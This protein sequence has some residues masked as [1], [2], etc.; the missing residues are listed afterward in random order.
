LSEDFLTLTLDGETYHRMDTSA[1]EW[2]YGYEVNLNLTQTQLELVKEGTV[3]FDHSNVI[4]EVNLYYQDGSSLYA[5]Y[6]KDSQR[7]RLIAML[8]D[9]NAVVEIEYWNNSNFTK[10]S[11]KDYK[12]NAIVLSERILSYCDYYYVFGHAEDLDIYTRPGALLVEQG[13]YYY[14]DFSE[15]KLDADK[16]TPWEHSSLAGYEITN[17]A[18]I[19]QLDRDMADYYDD[20]IGAIYDDE[21]TEDLSTAVL[22]GVFGIFP[23]VVLL[24]AVILLIRN[25]G[26]QRLTWAIT[27][28]LSAAELT[29]FGII[30][31]IFLKL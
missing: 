13:K 23:G 30:V 25:K 6:V 16:F 26:Y 21:F 19:Q 20:G 22:I 24:L 14:V 28:G 5:S 9:D 11:I 4:A 29:V 3:N 12:G 31:R 8:E 17:E 2:S 15:N 27:A 7:D 1:F 10:A 18:L